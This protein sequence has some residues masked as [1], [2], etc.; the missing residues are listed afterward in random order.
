MAAGR[1]PV[2]RRIGT[3]PS[4]APSGQARERRPV[5][6]AAVGPAAAPPDPELIAR[7]S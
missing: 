1:R 3:R 5:P 2:D 4:G 6:I 7:G